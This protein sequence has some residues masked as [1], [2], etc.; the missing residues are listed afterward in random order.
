MSPLT[1]VLIGIGLFLLAG[2]LSWALRNHGA[3]AQA[4]AGVGG[5]AGALIGLWGAGAALV[6]R[7]TY[8]LQLPG[9]MPGSTLHLGLDSLSAFFLLPVFFGA[10]VATLYG[11]SYLKHDQAKRRIGR[12]WFFYFL[13]AASMGLVTIAR[14]GLVF[15]IA[16]EVMAL[17][18]LFLVLFEHERP[19]SRRA[20]W[21]YMVAS[22]LGAA[23]LLVLFLLLS[24][25]QASLDFS[26]YA[27][28]VDARTVSPTLLFALAV[29]GFGSKAG[30]VP[31]HV[32]LPEAHPAAPSHASA[33]MSG[34]MIKMGIYGIVR[35]LALLGTPEESWG[36]ALVAIGA[37]SGILGVV[38]AL[39]QH[40]LKRLLAYHSVENIGIITLGL[41]LGVVGWARGET[42]LMVL[43]FAGGL[44]HVINHS[45]FKSLLFLGAGSV[46]HSTGTLELEK[47]GGLSKRMPVTAG[48]F[49]VGAAAIVGLP[50]LNGFISEFLIF[51]AGVAGVGTQ[52]ASVI[53]SAMVVV[54]SLGLIGG[55]AGACFVKAHGTVFLG[56]ARS[57]SAAEA[58]EV[59]VGMRFGMMVFAIACVLVGLGGCFVVPL[60]AAPLTV[61][62][63]QD[64]AL[65]LPPLLHAADSLG[66]AL[67]VFAAL[68]VV[69]LALFGVRSLLAKKQP[70]VE[71]ETWGCGY[72]ETT[73]RVQYTASSFAHPITRDLSSVLRTKESSVDLESLFP[74]RGHFHSHAPDFVLDLWLTPLF[75]RVARLA[76]RVRVLQQ[77][78][79]HLYVLYI[80]LA[81]VFMLMWLR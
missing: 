41:G 53:V 35:V 56:T 14:D 6:T 8:D 34:V 78:T 69:L 73:P 18:P 19:D 16:W 43:G 15:L 40:D 80:A 37:S 32:W 64:A 76:E 33:L 75:R 63:H 29:L 12:T 66:V 47:M 57:D 9:S 77:G 62:V 67:T 46:L 71:V 42:E 26:T 60:L 39:A 2:V 27:T 1:L 70:A 24:P 50:P 79:V 68:F 54:A 21:I 25:D 28:S 5:V 36:W 3:L 10:G 17:S 45:L 7:A 30:F 81:L 23:C 22:H 4:A 13:L 72:P 58:H 74:K 49:L 55:L 31:L 51:M 20:A 38:F 59:A 61:I 52:S 11:V 44:L 48:T 65:I